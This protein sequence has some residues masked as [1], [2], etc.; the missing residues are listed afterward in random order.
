MLLYDRKQELIGEGDDA[1]KTAAAH[2]D[3]G[4]IVAIKGDGG[5]HI[6]ATATD[7]AALTTLRERLGRSGQ[8]FAVMAEDMDAAKEFADVSPIEEGLLSDCRTPIV[9]LG[10]S[11]NYD[12]SEQIAPFLHNIG[13]MLPYSPIHHLLFHYGAE[14]AYVMTSANLPGLPMAISTKEAFS[15]INGIVD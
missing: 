2:L 9:I 4:A 10:K 3:R 6:A 1:I 15:E 5:I 7:D 11:E 12:L 14:S 13:V 8:P